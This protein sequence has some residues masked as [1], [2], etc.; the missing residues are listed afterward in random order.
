MVQGNQTHQKDCQLG[1]SIFT[2]KLPGADPSKFQN[3]IIKSIQDT[4]SVF[5]VYHCAE[6]WE[7]YMNYTAALTKKFQLREGWHND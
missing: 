5:V 4:D 7:N 2:W 1:W 6:E 3:G